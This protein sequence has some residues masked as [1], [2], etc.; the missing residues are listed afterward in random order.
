MLHHSCCC[1]HGDL[2]ASRGPQLEWASLRQA[3][4]CCLVLTHQCTCSLFCLPEALG[5]TGRL[6]APQ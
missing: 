6:A 3:R 4:S 2:T 5:A 1:Q